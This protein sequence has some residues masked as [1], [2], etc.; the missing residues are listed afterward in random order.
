VNKIKEDEAKC[1]A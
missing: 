1:N